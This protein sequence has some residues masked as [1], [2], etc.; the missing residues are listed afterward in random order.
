MWPVALRLSQ[1]LAQM[2]QAQTQLGY[3]KSVRAD[4]TALFP[5]AWR[6]RERWLQPG[7]PIVTVIDVDHLWVQTDVEESLIDSIQFN[8][9]LNVRLPSGQIIEGRC[10]SRAWKI[11]SRRSAT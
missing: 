7:G 3:T 10:S 1:A 2:D 9:T 8:Q 6:G 5:C 4:R 11:I